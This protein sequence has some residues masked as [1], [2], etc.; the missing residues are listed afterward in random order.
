MMCFHCP[1]GKPAV[2]IDRGGLLFVTPEFRHVVVTQPHVVIKL[3][4]YK[5]YMMVHEAILY[6]I[7]KVCYLVQYDAV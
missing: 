5:C 1:I 7:G 4:H 3:Q 2:K 6:F